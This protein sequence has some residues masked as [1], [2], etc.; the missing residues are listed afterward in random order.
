MSIPF[1]FLSQLFAPNTKHNLTFVQYFYSYL[2][3][4]QVKTQTKGA[5]SEH[6]VYKWL[7]FPFPSFSNIS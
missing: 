5:S 6:I 7:S 3:E 1:S 4:M 2:P